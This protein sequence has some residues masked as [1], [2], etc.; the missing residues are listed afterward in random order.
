MQ[1]SQNSFP[2]EV[3]RKTERKK[4][5]WKV[6]RQEKVEDPKWGTY[7]REVEEIEGN[8]E[9]CE[10]WIAEHEGNFVVRRCCY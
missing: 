7:I 6:F 2:N 5:M 1:I 10:R 4:E 9:Q 8:L 3:K